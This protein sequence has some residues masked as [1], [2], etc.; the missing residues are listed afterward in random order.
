MKI[1]KVEFTTEEQDQ[2]FESLTEKFDI[3]DSDLYSKN[4]KTIE[5][6]LNEIINIECTLEFYSEGYLEKDTNAEVISQRSIIKFKLLFFDNDG[7]Q[8]ETNVDLEEKISDYYR[9]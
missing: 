7:N 5:F 6:E 3:N 9:I 1:V 8:V 4:G 2:I